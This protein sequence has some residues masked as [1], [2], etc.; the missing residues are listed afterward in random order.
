MLCKTLEPRR[1]E[2]KIGQ[3]RR[4]EKRKR[5]INGVCRSANTG[6]VKKNYARFVT[7]ANVYFVLVSC[8]WRI[9]CQFASIVCGIFWKKFWL[10]ELKVGYARCR[11]IEVCRCSEMLGLN[12]WK[13]VWSLIND[14]RMESELIEMFCEYVVLFKCFG[15]LIN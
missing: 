15:K 1:Q 2:E 12:G 5:E 14:M 8:A 10:L 6:W 7:V 4:S 11:E 9:R 13:Y 3:L